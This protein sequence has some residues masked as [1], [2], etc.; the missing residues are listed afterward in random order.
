MPGRRPCSTPWWRRI[1]KI[2]NGS[3]TALIDPAPAG[4]ACC[5]PMPTRPRHTALAK[6]AENSRPG[7]GGAVV[8]GNF[9]HS[10]RPPGGWKAACALH[11]TRPTPATRSPA[12]S[13][14]ERPRSSKKPRR[15]LGHREFAQSC[16]LAGRIALAQ[17]PAR[18][19]AAPLEPRPRSARPAP[20]EFERLAVPRPGRAGPRAPRKTD[21]ARP[22]IERLQR[23]GYHPIDPLAASILD[24]ALLPGKP[25]RELSPSASGTAFTSAQAVL[26]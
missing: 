12:P 14:W 13:I 4:G 1:R 10:W 25:R 15:R 26:S 21:E 11:P 18:R 16:I 2:G 20:G 5:S 23:F 9:T 22:L 3:C 19:R 17:G 7:R 8:P 24:A 6:P